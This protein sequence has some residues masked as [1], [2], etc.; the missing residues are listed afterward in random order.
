MKKQKKLVVGNWKMNPV[1]L[2]EA[3]AIVRKVKTVGS[4]VKKTSIVLCPPHIYL[5]LVSS[6]KA[7]NIFFGAQNAFHEGHGHFTGE[8]SFAQISEFNVDYVIVG[9]SERREMGET[10][11]I[12][13]KKLLSVVGAKM[14]A[15]LCV[16]EKIHDTHGDYLRFIKD[17]LLECLK[18]IQKNLVENVVIAYEPIWAVGADEAMKPQDIHE[19]SIFI[20]KILRDTFGSFADH[21]QVLYGGDVTVSNATEIVRDGFVQGVL[22]GRESLK[23]ADFIEIIKEID[24][25]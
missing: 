19:I 18:N 11:E 15:I 21:V 9:H 12:I 22:I 10:N 25:I 24:S 20:K 5:P 13:N 16:G 3:K 14:T 6:G 17:Q 1:T 8:V 23:P 7:A 4:K 2:E